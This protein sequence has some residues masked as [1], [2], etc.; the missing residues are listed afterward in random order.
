MV[1]REYPGCCL[2]SCIAPASGSA[3][4][5]GGQGAQKARYILSPPLVRVVKGQLFGLSLTASSPLQLLPAIIRP[6]SCRHG[7]VCF[8]C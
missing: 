8:S 2:F 3:F 7:T 1:A 6:S 4:A 5:K